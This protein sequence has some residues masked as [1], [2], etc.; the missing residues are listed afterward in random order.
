M[1]TKTTKTQR[2]LRLKD[3]MNRKVEGVTRQRLFKKRLKWTK[4]KPVF[5]D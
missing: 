5:P 4:E 3:E 1:F 2:D